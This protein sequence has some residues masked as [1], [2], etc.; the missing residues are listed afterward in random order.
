MEAGN[1][2]FAMRLEGSS[3]GSPERI[4][5]VLTCDGPFEHPPFSSSPDHFFPPRNSLVLPPRA[6][7]PGIRVEA[8][9]L[10]GLLVVATDSPLPDDNEENRQR[11][12][13]VPAAL[14]PAFLSRE[15]TSENKRP[16][17]GYFYRERTSVVP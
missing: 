3:S 4:A 7:L 15:N 2:K 6:K 5:R 8:L 11:F 13:R 17:L 9:D 12:L 16:M 14:Q 10:G 1:S